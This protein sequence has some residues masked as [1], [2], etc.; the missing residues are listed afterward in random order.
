MLYLSIGDRMRLAS[1]RTA[2]RPEDMAYSLLGI[3]GVNMPLLYG[4]GENAFFRL[5]LE[6]IRQ[7]DDESIFAWQDTR[8]DKRALNYGLLARHASYFSGARGI[9][10][11]DFIMR[12]HYE[13]TNKGIRIICHFPNEFLK[14]I[15]LES[16]GK[17]VRGVRNWDSQR[18]I[19]PLNIFM[20]E[21]GSSWPLVLFL[22]FMLRESSWSRKP[23][24]PVKYFGAI[25]YA[26]LAI[27]CPTADIP[28]PASVL[29]GIKSRRGRDWDVFCGE[30][31][32]EHTAVPVYFPL[33]TEPRQ[34]FPNGT[35]RST[36]QDRGASGINSD[37][38][39]PYM[40]SRP[41]P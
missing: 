37:G 31:D 8:L 19:M 33:L 4:E 35:F 24:Q 14:D 12:E 18:L 27:E 34:S 32:D 17:A 15:K 5:Q 30:D 39:E 25:R 7:S 3:F 40:L 36:S 11:Y 41:A 13:V 1:K 16:E 29:E 9:W 2:T 28:G 38:I 22:E 26:L 23:E 21:A 10:R 6:I 20:E